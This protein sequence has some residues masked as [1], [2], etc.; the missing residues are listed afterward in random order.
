M[1]PQLTHIFAPY[2][3]QVRVELARAYTA[4]ADV[5]GART[6]LREAGALLR[7]GPDFGTLGEQVD[8]L[9]AQLDSAEVRAPG[10]ST[11]TAAELRLL[12]LLATHLTFREIG[13]R[14]YLSRHTVKSHAISVYRKLDVTSRNDAVERARELGCCRHQTSRPVIHAIGVMPTRPWR[15]LI[16]EWLSSY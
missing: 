11:L 6:L 1:R 2:S 7:R 14:L 15:C 16:S 5:A 12:P 13:E 3:I 9:R 10:A 8:E 4:R